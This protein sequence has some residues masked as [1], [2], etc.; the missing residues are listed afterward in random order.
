MGWKESCL[1]PMPAFSALLTRSL[2]HP[3]RRAIGIH[4]S[5]GSTHTHFQSPTDIREP[6]CSSSACASPPTRKHGLYRRNERT[7]P[8]V[9]PSASDT[10]PETRAHRQTGFRVPKVK[11]MTANPDHEIH[12]YSPSISC[13][14][15]HR[16]QTTYPLSQPCSHIPMFCL[17]I[18]C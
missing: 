17:L 8:R 15:A 13:R 9:C 1:I 3:I 12:L 14:R 16:S 18:H 5:R 6:I 4:W 11:R 2:S 7:R 10:R